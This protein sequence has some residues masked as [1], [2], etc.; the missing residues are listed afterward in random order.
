MRLKSLK[1]LVVKLSAV[2]VFTAV[3]GCGIFDPHECN[4]L[5][6]WSIA[7]NMVDVTT[8]EAISADSIL[9][10]A[11]APGFADTA[12]ALGSQFS[13]PSVVVALVTNRVG[14]YDVTVL[15]TGYERWDRLGVEVVAEDE[16][17]VRGVEITAELRPQT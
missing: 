1:S 13:G 15:A 9:V 3:A 10:T 5:L 7:V 12:T 11:T 14:T 17:F 2:T 16:C 4:A 8:G 6:Q